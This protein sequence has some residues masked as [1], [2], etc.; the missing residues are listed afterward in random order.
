[1]AEK[2]SKPQVNVEDLKTRI[3]EVM[4]KEILTARRRMVEDGG[5]YTR[6]DS[7]QGGS[8]SRPD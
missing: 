6:P 5:T 2:E 7:T 8:Y 3:L 1:M 4:D